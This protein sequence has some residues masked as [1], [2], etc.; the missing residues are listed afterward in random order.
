MIRCN[1]CNGMIWRTVAQ[2]TVTPKSVGVAERVYDVP[3]FDGFKR[4]RWNRLVPREGLPQPLPME[5]RKGEID[6]KRHHPRL[7]QR[8]G[9]VE[10]SRLET[11]HVARVGQ[12]VGE[13]S[14]H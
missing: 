6:E 2:R 3:P 12:S 13:W 9:R 8:C 5:S 4:L 11:N 10:R 14:G 7:G 1:F